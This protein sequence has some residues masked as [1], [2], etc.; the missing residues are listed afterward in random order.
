MTPAARVRDI[1]LDKSRLEEYERALVP[2]AIAGDLQAI[3]TAV[4]VQERRHTLTGANAPLRTDPVQLALEVA[5]PL[6]S[7]DQLRKIFDEWRAEALRSGDAERE[8]EDAATVETRE[9]EIRP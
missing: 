1:W 5:Q 8:G 3:A 4:R 9:G 6:S 7:T 2:A